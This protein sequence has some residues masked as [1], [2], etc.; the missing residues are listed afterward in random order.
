MELDPSAHLSLFLGAFARAEHPPR[1]HAAPTLLAVR[2]RARSPTLQTGLEHDAKS[3]RLL[4]RAAPP[5]AQAETPSA[6]TAHSQ[7]L[8]PLAQPLSA[9][10]TSTSSLTTLAEDSLYSARMASPAIT[11]AGDR[12]VRLVAHSSPRH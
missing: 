6:I 8:A 3:P 12:M 5:P 7:C 11:L 2:S 9:A 1:M 10:S 4:V